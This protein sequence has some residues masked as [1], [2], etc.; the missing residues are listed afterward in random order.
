MQLEA[1]EHRVL[2]SA[3]LASTGLLTITGTADDDRISMVRVNA[4]KT[5][6]ALLIVTEKVT[7]LKGDGSGTLATVE[8]T[9]FTLASVKSIVINAGSGNDSVSVAGGRTYHIAIPSTI[10]GESGD[11]SL[12]GGDADDVLSGGKGDDLITGGAGN[13]RLFGNEGADR[14]TGGEGADYLNGGLDNDRLYADDGGGTDTVDGG[15]GTAPND[16][17]VTNPGD[18]VTGVKR[19]KQPTA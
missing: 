1:L 7:T 4:T 19:V 16:Y 15:G 8:T 11:D 3:V 17:A 10:N 13:D 5:K 2:L 18:V 9:N 6:P 14:L 12:T